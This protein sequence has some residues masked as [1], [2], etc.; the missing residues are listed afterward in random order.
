MAADS[1]VRATRS[2]GSGWW[3]FDL[4]Q[5]R[6]SAVSYLGGLGG[7]ADRAHARLGVPAHPGADQGQLVQ[8]TQRVRTL[9]ER[10]LDLVI[11]PA[12]DPT[13]AQRLAS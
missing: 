3:T 12:R 10:M 13:A 6:A 4:P 11:L 2:S 1:T 9:K 7:D 5:A 8:T